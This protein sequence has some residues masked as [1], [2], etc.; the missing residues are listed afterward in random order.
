M[1]ALRVALSFL[2]LSYGVVFAQWQQSAGTE[3]RN[4]QSLLATGNDTFAGGATGAYYSSDSAGS[5][6]P[7]NQGN[8][9]AGPT[10]SLTA[11]AK[12]VFSCTSQG[13][14]RT[15]DRGAPWVSKSSGLGNLLGS[16]ISFI[17]P[18]IFVATPTG[19]F[20]SGD[21]GDTWQSAGL[22]GK[23][24]RCIA[25]RPGLILAGTNGDG[26]FKSTDGGSTWFPV[27]AGLMT[28]NFRA[29]EI[30]GSTFFAAG[31]IGTGIYRST[32]GGTSWVLLTGGLEGAGTFRGFAANAQLIAAAGFGSGVFYSVDNGDRWIKLND[33]LGDLTL[34]DV[35]LTPTHLVAAT[36]TR[37]VFRYELSN[38]N[39]GTSPAERP[40]IT[41][42]PVSV[43][44]LSG[45]TAV[46]SVMATNSPTSYQWRRNGVSV[47]NTTPGANGATLLLPAA[48][49]DRAG[50]Y[51]VVVT[52]GA[53]SVTSNSATLT[54]VANSGFGRLLSVSTRGYVGTEGDILIPGFVIAGNGAKRL[55][56][57]AAGPALSQFSVTGVL[58]DPQLAVFKDSTQLFIND[59]WSADAANAAAVTSAGTSVGAFAL[60]GGSKDAALV[61]SLDPGTYTIHVSGVGN[62]TG[63]AIVEVYDLDVADA[64]KS[65]LVNLATRALVQA[66][67]GPL[68]SGFV[69]QGAVAKAVLIRATGPALAGFG[70]TGTLALPKL[71]VFDSTSSP[72]AENT[73]WESS[74]ISDQ[75]IA[76]SQR[77]GAFALTRGTADSVVLS[78]LPPGG[79]TAQVNGADG[80]SGVT[81]VEVYEL[82]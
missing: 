48:T 18:D 52:N 21:E 38:L 80:G 63:T 12:H 46:F 27:T 53:G 71:T 59:N 39:L 1:Q 45:S 73:G 4:F 56:I 30:K 43:S 32:D 25:G 9:S 29:M 57:R 40:V 16:A 5:F 49:A 34:F 36:N 75:I 35:E 41:A 37:G 23:D 2:V 20:R 64:N 14:F 72:I 79:Y 51:T 47:P 3:G 24:V 17:A 15:A 26:M 77:V 76:A 13:V 19:V 74:G 11:S 70:V 61:T 69:V 50:A 78:V 44:V 7:A 54:V 66:G 33:G 65:R 82:P 28:A 8:D 31:G 68:I 22:Q 6:R 62:T 42:Q 81:L 10:R 55:L 67:A 58:A 60:A